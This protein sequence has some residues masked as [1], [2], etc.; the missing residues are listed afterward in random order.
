VETNRQT[1]GKHYPTLRSH[2]KLLHVGGMHI[3]D[4]VPP[5]GLGVGRVKRLFQINEAWF[6]QVT[7]DKHPYW[8]EVIPH[9][10]LSPVPPSQLSVDDGEDDLDIPF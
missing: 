8:M 6:V 3:D 4:P 10:A 5:G 2:F 7:H 1:V 9:Q